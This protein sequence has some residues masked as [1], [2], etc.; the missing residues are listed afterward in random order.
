MLSLVLSK[1]LLISVSR[2]SI[3]LIVHVH[4]LCMIMYIKSVFLCSLEVR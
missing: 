1:H 2:S 3:Y 4:V